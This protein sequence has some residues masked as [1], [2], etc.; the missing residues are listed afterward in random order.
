MLEIMFMLTASLLTATCQDSDDQQSSTQTITI[1]TVENGD[2]VATESGTA[3]VTSETQGDGRKSV[4]VRV[5]SSTD[6]QQKPKQADSK[7]AV[8]VKGSVVVIGPDG[9][10]KEYSLDG[11]KLLEGSKVV[12][13]QA[14][15]NVIS[16]DGDEE[17][18]AKEGDIFLFEE[19]A[20]S[21]GEERWVI[22]VQCEEAT[23]LLRSHL[24]LGETGLVV[25]DVR[26]ETPAS[27]AGLQVHDIIVKI[28][29]KELTSRETLIDAVLDSEGKPMKLSLIRAGDP[30]SLE[31]TPRKMKVQVNVAPAETELGLLTAEGLQKNGEVRLKRIHPG[32]LLEGGVPNWQGDVDGLLRQL[33]EMADSQ[34]SNAQAHVFISPDMGKKTE[35]ASKDVVELEKAVSTLQQEVKALQAKL[36]ELTAKEGKTSDGER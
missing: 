4:T 12:S 8:R 10:R 24:K 27:E 22:G 14:I 20:E 23:D 33:R 6:D 16:V 2:V 34:R 17:M 9:V 28:N 1:S 35:S 32:V 25:L 30:I 26:D 3:Q 21:A 19:K 7:P 18:S 15:I 29:D 13:D 5:H 31:V 36:A 11:N